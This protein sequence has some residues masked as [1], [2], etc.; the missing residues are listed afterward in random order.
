MPIGDMKGVVSG[1]EVYAVGTSLMVPVG[2]ELI[3]RVI[4]GIGK[5]LDGKGEIFTRDKYPVEGKEDESS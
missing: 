1:A 3:G 4:S 2:K 5:P